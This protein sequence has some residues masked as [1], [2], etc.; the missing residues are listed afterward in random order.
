M[1]VSRHITNPTGRGTNREAAVPSISEI[2]ITKNQDCS[3]TRLFR[4]SLH[5]EGK[6]VRIDFVTTDKDRF[7]A[8]MHVDLENVLISNFNVSGH[9]GDSSSRPVESLS[10]NFTKITFNTTHMDDKNRT[11]K[12][13]RATW[14]AATGKGA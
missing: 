10:L 11:G 2:I 13:D 3:S 8:Y 12:P 9:G 14:D 5:G 7:E 4:L 6:K 1:G